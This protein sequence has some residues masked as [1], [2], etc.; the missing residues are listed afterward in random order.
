M[1][2]VR[3]LPLAFVAAPLIAQS[4]DNAVPDPSPAVQYAIQGIGRTALGLGKIAESSWFQSPAATL[5][6]V[7]NFP[8]RRVEPP[9]TENMKTTR[10]LPACAPR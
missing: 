4:V 1:R 3:F 10:G 6:S 2:V 9:V 7:S 5:G 8:I